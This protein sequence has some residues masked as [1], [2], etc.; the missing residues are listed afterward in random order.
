MDRNRVLFEIGASAWRISDFC[1]ACGGG[2][3]LGFLLLTVVLWRYGKSRRLSRKEAASVAMHAGE[4]SEVDR[5]VTYAGPAAG[6]EWEVSMSIGDLREAYHDQ[7]WFRFLGL[8]SA[9]LTIHVAAGMLIW[10]FGELTGSKLVAGMGVG[11]AL[12]FLGVCAFMWW[13][14]IYTDLK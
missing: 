12:M 13:A 7:D 11:W 14:A 9:V 8:G 6:K 2:L 5:A 1:W 10:G 4:V 3:V